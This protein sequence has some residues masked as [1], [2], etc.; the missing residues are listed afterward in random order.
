MVN[1]FTLVFTIFL[2]IVSYVPGIEALDTEQKIPGAHRGESVDHIENTIEAIEAALNDPNYQFIEI[3]VQYTKD[4]ILVVH[5]DKK[6]FRLQLQPG[7]LPELTY[8][9]LRE[10]STYHI[11][12]Y[13]EIMDLVGTEKTLNIEIKSQGNFE[14]DKEIVDYVIKDCRKRGI[15]K[16]TIISS[17]SK[18]IVKYV[19]ETYPEVKNGKIYLILPVTY[20]PIKSFAEKLFQET[21]E[22]GADYLMLHGINIRSYQLL[23]ELKPSDQIL[24]FWYF[25]NQMY[26]ME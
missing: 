1:T 9:E 3:D 2:V 11:P 25:N 22:M 18:D 7:S 16:N 17:I 6:L 4:K 5:H 24:A 21:D 15:L 19:S 8:Q 20:L 26:L 14:D 12:L 13:E 23:N 10:V